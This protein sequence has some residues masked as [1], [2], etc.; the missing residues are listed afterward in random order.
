M[1]NNC[2]FKDGAMRRDPRPASP[3]KDFKHGKGYGYNPRIAKSPM[4]LDQVKR[5]KEINK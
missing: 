1:I 3:V 4:Q 5:E 2:Y